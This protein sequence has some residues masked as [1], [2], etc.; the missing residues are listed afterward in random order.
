[1]AL[2]I[3]VLL[4]TFQGIYKAMEYG[5]PQYHISVVGHW[6]NTGN[7]FVLMDENGTYH[8][9]RVINPYRQ[10]QNVTGMQCSPCSP[11]LNPIDNLQDQLGQMLQKRL[12][13]DDP[14]ADVHRYLQCSKGGH[15]L[16]RDELQSSIIVG[17]SMSGLFR[18]EPSS[19]TGY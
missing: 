5:I 6:S 11:D 12:Q 15:G 14:L 7:G 10:T 16:H 2:P 4:F 13:P 8:P 19:Y 9:V 18:H 17:R 1:M 3:S